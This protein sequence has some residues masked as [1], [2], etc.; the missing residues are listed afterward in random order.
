MR[1]KDVPKAAAYVVFHDGF[2]NGAMDVWPASSLAEAQERVTVAN[3][4]LDSMGE[5][6]GSYRAYTK[7]PRIKVY[8][9]Y[10]NP[11]KE[12]PCSI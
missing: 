7:L 8:K 6:G 4:E 1:I 5:D 3:L 9:Y 12:T 10:P 2:D 11:A